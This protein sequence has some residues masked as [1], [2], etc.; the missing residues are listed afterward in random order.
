MIDSV[1]S[2][3]QARPSGLASVRSASRMMTGTKIAVAPTTPTSPAMFAR[4]V[5]E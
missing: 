2:V 1:Y 5:S 4:T 3:S